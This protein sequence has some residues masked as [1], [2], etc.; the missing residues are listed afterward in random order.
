MTSTTRS[1]KTTI[2]HLPVMITL[3]INIQVKL[4]KSKKITATL[5]TVEKHLQT[6]VKIKIILMIP[7][8]QTNKRL[9]LMDKKTKLQMIHQ[10]TIKFNSPRYIVKYS[11][12]INKICKFKFK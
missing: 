2:R 5:K 1:L 9:I 8:L 7:R 3:K 11:D 6:A 4:L 10:I 12:K